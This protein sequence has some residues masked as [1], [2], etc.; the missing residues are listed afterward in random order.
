MAAGW[1]DRIVAAAAAGGGG[2]VGDHSAIRSFDEGSDDDDSDSD[3][4]E[5]VPQGQAGAVRRSRAA[6]VREVKRR[7]MRDL[8]PGQSRCLL[9]PVARDDD[10]AVADREGREGGFR[11]RG[12]HGFG[13]RFASNSPESF[14]CGRLKA[15]D[16][17]ALVVVVVVVVVVV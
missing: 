7:R 9:L 3:D 13:A 2:T 14:S 11:R 1:M 5:Q 17:R 16:Y 4:D 12:L 10:A 8:D 6:S 15:D